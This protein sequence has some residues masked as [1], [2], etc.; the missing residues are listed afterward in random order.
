MTQNCGPDSSIMLH[1]SVNGDNSYAGMQY[2]WITSC[3]SKSKSQQKPD[4]FNPYFLVL[5][6][7]LICSR[8]SFAC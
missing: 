4:A 3:F 1:V 8:V 7:A 6:T 5:E 2:A